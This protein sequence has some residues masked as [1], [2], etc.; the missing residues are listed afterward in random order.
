MKA[1][2]KDGDWRGRILRHHLPLA[3]ATAVVLTVFLTVPLF[4]ADA[5]PHADIVSGTLPQARRA[6]GETPDA[7]ATVHGTGATPAPGHAAGETSPPSAHGGDQSPQPSHGAQ[8]AAPAAHGSGQTALPTVVDERMAMPGLFLGLS[9]RDLTVATGYVA[10]GLLGLTLLIGPA[11]L[12]R[13]RRNPVS[14]YLRRD[15]GAWTAAF[16]VVHV[17]FGLQ[18]HGRISE[19]LSYFFAADGR[20]WLNAFGLGNW[21]GLAATLIVVGLLALSSDFALRR[22]KAGPWKQMQRLNYALFALVIAH[23][24]FYGALLRTP[25]PYTLLLA[26]SVIAVVLGQGLGVWL[27]RRKNSRAAATSAA[28]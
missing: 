2:S 24:L 21:T 10:L 28:G 17:I 20:P 4:D 9:S 19:F 12:F 16:S 14:S 15:V 6:S 23:A 11:N 26:L 5:Y 3:V 22:L 7:S 25:S 27:W 18:V 1:R 8:T 13:R